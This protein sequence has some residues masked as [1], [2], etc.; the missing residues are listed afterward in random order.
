MPYDFLENQPEAVIET[1]LNSEVDDLMTEAERRFAKAKY[2]ES[3]IKN[4]GFDG[5]DSPIAT[6][7]AKEVQNFCRDRLAVLLGIRPQASLGA[8]AGSGPFTAEEVKILK[9][10]AGRFLKKP[11][12]QQELLP[13]AE[14]ELRKAPSP[15]TPTPRAAAAKAP[16][17]PSPAPKGK[18]KPTGESI[19]IPQADGTER[20]YQKVVDPKFG[21]IWIGENGLRYLLS[22]NEAGQNYMKSIERQA[23]PSGVKPIPP[24]TGDMM[25]LVAARHAEKAKNQE[26][27]GRPDMPQV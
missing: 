3:Y 9:Q 24:L 1:G 23:K 10:V 8:D 7:T 27:P 2:F 21:D 17:A 26:T 4:A 20:V 12:L 11:G 5:D 16:A 25:A 6:E 14:P 15:R 13:T 19:S 22:K 18:A